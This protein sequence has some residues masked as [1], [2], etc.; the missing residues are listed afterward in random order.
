MIEGIGYRCDLA[1][2]GYA[3]VEAAKRHPYD[4]VLMDC[5]MPG[6]DGYEATRLIR[7]WEEKSDGSRR[8]PIV[9]V[10][11]HAM[12]G[13]RERCMDAGMDDYMTKPVDA[14]R[15]SAMITKWLAAKPQDVML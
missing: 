14:K 15:L 1:M 7:T 4:L 8:V 3:A 5:Q 9:A 2:D 12:S 6:M 11:A 13:D 10:T